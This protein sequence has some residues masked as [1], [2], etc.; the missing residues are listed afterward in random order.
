MNAVIAGTSP[1]KVGAVTTSAPALRSKLLLAMIKAAFSVTHCPAPP[2]G[3]CLLTSSST[4]G[5]LAVGG[6][7][8]L[9]A[10]ALVGVATGGALLTSWDGSYSQLLLAMD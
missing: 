8:E 1:S 10:D 2:V 4:P 9:L 7:F 6:A 5:S 3:G